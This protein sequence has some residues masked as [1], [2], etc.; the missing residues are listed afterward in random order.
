MLYPR[1][2]PVLLVRNGGLV[3][4]VRFADDKYVGDPINA[5][6]IFNE[7]EVDEIMVLDI[8]ASKENREPNYDLIRK[9]AA[10]CRMPLCYGGGVTKVEQFEK[11]VE[12]GAEKVAVCSA[13]A[14][15]DTLISSAAQRVGGQSVVGVID[16]RKTGLLKRAEVVILNGSHR[17]G[18]RPP[19]LAMRYAAAGAGEIVINSVDRDGTMEGYDLEMI[20][21]VKELIRV[22]LTALGG[23]GRF[24]DFTSLI[25]KFGIIGAAAGSVFVFKGKYRAVL[26]QYPKKEEKEN[27]FKTALEKLI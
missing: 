4:T 10:E 15:S 11:L 21:N 18:L 8:D 9:I 17:T 27:L 12:L 2:I 22:P 7:K 6:R 14:T 20:A 16:Y 5:V 3:K 1:L 26:I 25:T 23:A 24:E 13:A 19:D